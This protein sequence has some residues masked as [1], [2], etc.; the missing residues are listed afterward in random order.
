MLLFIYKSYLIHCMRNLFFLKKI[1]TDDRPEKY[2]EFLSLKEQN[3]Y[4]LI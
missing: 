1:T 4:I 3:L 2:F